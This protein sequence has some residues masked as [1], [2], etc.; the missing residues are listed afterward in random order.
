MA[1]TI[2]DLP[3][4]PS[5]A[6]RRW[7]AGLTWDAFNSADN[8]RATQ[9]NGLTAALSFHEAATGSEATHV[10]LPRTKSAAQVVGCATF[11]EPATDLYPAAL[12]LLVSLP[13]RS[14][15]SV[16]RLGENK[17][18]LL[19]VVEGRILPGSDV[20]CDDATANLRVNETQNDVP[21]ITVYRFGSDALPGEVL[22]TIKRVPR[23]TCLV[24]AKKQ[25]LVKWGALGL[26]AAGLC[27]VAVFLLVAS[28]KPAELTAEERAALIAANSKPKSVEPPPVTLPWSA[29]PSF[30]DTLGRCITLYAETNGL[31]GGWQLND[32][33]CD[34]NQTVT[35][36]GR[37][38]YGRFSEPPEGTAFDPRSPNRAE[39][40]TPLDPLAPQGETP[41]VDAKSASAL[42]MDVARLND[43]A[44]DIQW[45]PE[46]TRMVP[47]VNGDSEV[48]QRLGYAENQVTITAQTLPGV[49]FF[50]ALA[51]IPSM[52][53]SQ[54]NYTGSGWQLGLALFSTP[55]D[56]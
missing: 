14:W 48:T 31:E 12:L 51:Q 35:V 25:R 34:Q 36:W 39:E 8:S 2:L 22:S 47:S 50:S 46:A 41:L 3:G 26:A 33:R 52:S 55:L 9:K 28:D 24:V 16:C 30:V 49:E 37:L 40:T 54:L 44:V 19:E 21:G 17:T 13:E 38:G 4:L 43:A 7:V 1:L 6:N 32:W 45:G 15:V 18:W 27:A 23:L 20:V 11:E 56:Q 10:V 42:I 53:L 5:K 29:T